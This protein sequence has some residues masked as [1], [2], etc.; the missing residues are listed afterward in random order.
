MPQDDSH[1]LRAPPH[2]H[3]H[4]PVLAPPQARVEAQAWQPLLQKVAAYAA[5]LD[6]PRDPS[7]WFSPGVDPT[8]AALGTL[9]LGDYDR[10]A[11]STTPSLDVKARV[12]SVEVLAVGHRARGG[13]VGLARPQGLAHHGHSLH[14]GGGGRG[15]FCC[16]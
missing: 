8:G 6:R 11:G 7:P 14:T 16:A 1:R 13:S 2:H 3:H 9:A 10:R 15:R 12:G 5:F 4:H